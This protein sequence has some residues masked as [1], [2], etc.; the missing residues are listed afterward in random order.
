MCGRFTLTATPEM[1]AA[2]LGLAEV[3]LLTPRYNIA[4]TQGVPLVRLVGE[5]R[6]LDLLTWGLVPSWAKDR[7]IAASLINARAETAQE[8]PAFRAAFKRRR[9]LV[10]ADG[11]FEWRKEGA[12]K[13]PVWFHLADDSVLTFAGLWETWTSPDGAVV[14]SCTILTTAANDL[15]RPVHDR[16]PVILP[17][18]QRDAWLAPGELPPGGAEALLVPLDPKLMAAHDVDPR[19]GNPR[20]DE[21]LAVA[22]R[23]RQG[24]LF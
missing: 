4:P 17:P 2:E 9:G 18:E 16:M 1:V 15:V 24:S 11:F 19:V 23:P 22:P 20:F 21:P 3:P 7:K 13:Q 5:A 10:V 12:S 8:K 14:E 6:R